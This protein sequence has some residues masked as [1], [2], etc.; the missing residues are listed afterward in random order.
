MQNNLAIA[1][2]ICFLMIGA[3]SCLLGVGMQLAKAVLTKTMSWEELK[4]V[5]T[6]AKSAGFALLASMGFT[7]IA[8]SFA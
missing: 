2:G 4:L 8:W 7:F 6:L 5:P 3:G 1:F